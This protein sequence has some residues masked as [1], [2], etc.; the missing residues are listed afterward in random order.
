MLLLN[1]RYEIFPDTNNLFFLLG[2]LTLE[3]GTVRLYPNFGK[4]LPFNAA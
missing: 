4:W 1:E 2:C 3:H